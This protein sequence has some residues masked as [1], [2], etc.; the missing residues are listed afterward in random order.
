MALHLVLA[1]RN[2]AISLNLEVVYGFLR[3]FCVILINELVSEVLV[4]VVAYHHI[5]VHVLIWI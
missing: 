1:R 3:H 5:D 2:L 4:F